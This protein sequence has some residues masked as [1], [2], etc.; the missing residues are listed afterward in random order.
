MNFGIDTFGI[1]T[2]FGSNNA[3]LDH[4]A[5][6]VTNSWVWV[7]V[8]VA[9][10]ILIIKNH[11][12]MQQI[13]LC[14]GCAVLGVLLA[15][16]LTSL[17]TKPMTERLRPCNDYA[18][19]YLVDIAS[20]VRSKDY[21]FFSSHAATSMSL[22]VFFGVMVRSR[23]L[24]VLLM[25]WSLSIVWTRLYLGQH[26]LSDIIVG[27]L[28]GTITGAASYALYSLTSS[29]IFRRIGFISSKY[30]STGFDRRDIDMVSCIIVLSYIIII[31]I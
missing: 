6:A 7:P 24:A 22:V 28:W 25:A 27:M 5:L 17:I 21:S 11:D 4:F 15:T 3:F 10:L 18:Y 8:Y 1:E 19:R 31:L 16:A 13:M 26:F 12:N 9:F 29:K 20:D 14:F 30:T 23:Q 2:F